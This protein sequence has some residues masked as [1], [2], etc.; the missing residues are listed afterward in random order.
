[1][2]DVIIKHSSVGITTVEYLQKFYMQMVACPLCKKEDMRWT[3]AGNYPG[4]I[5]CLK[6][7]TS[8]AKSNC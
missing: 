1:M 7:V 2:K 3:F 8:N 4:C 6:K 5:E